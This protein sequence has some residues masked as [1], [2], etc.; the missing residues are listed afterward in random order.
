[1]SVIIWVPEGGV[2]G[3]PY[4]YMRWQIP[5]AHVAMLQLTCISELCA[6]IAKV[7]SPMSQHRRCSVYLPDSGFFLHGLSISVFSQSWN[8]RIA[9]RSFFGILRQKGHTIYSVLAPLDVAGRTK[10]EH[11][12]D[13]WTSGIHHSSHA[14]WSEMM[15]RTVARIHLCM[16]YCWMN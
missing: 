6:I 2:R 14:M 15:S 16:P 4:N 13:G 5:C 10:R 12:W 8:A 11:F 7:I 1:M 9:H 3:H